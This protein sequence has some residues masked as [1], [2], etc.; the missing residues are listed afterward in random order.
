[1]TRLKTF[2]LGLLGFAILAGVATLVGWAL[3]EFFQYLSAVPKE[4]GAALVAA[5]ATVL[6]ATITV[7]VGRYY[8]R[9]KELDTLYRDKK[10]EI[11]DE[12]LKEFFSLFWRVEKDEPEKDLVPFLREFTRK[13]VLWSGPEVIEAFVAWKDHLAKG[14]P[15]AQS[16]FLT[17]AFLLAI[18]RDLRHSNKGLRKGFYARMFLREGN[19]FLAMA[20]KNPN[21]ALAA[22]AEAEKILT[23][24][25]TT[26]G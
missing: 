13:L 14:T 1:M 16:I 26:N 19:L 4:L 8:E 11:Y 23:Q 18:R 15:D 9:K 6:V 21:V 20:A 12:F 7:M 17:E 25:E 2:L 5:T 22:L 24:S 10:T 3:Y